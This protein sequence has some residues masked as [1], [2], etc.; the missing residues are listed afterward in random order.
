MGRISILL[1]FRSRRKVHSFP[2]PQLSKISGSSIAE[3]AV[4]YKHRAGPC[5]RCSSVGQGHDT[6]RCSA[7]EMRRHRSGGEKGGFAYLPPQAAVPSG[8]VQMRFQSKGFS[9]EER[10][11]TGKAFGAPASQGTKSCARMPTAVQSSGT[12]KAPAAAAHPSRSDAPRARPAGCQG[13]MFLQ[14]VSPG[15]R[16]AAR[17]RKDIPGVAGAQHPAAVQ[18]HHFRGKDGR[19]RPGCG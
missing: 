8:A 15:C 9:L 18:Y 16:D 14:P 5:Q 6:F 12:W 11:A 10:A 1:I 4:R 2:R 19:L 7:Q 17:V 13:R 3:F